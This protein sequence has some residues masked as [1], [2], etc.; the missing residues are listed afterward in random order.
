MVSFSVGTWLKLFYISGNKE[1]I[2]GINSLVDH[3]SKNLEHNQRSLYQLQM[4]NV[5]LSGCEASLCEPVTHLISQQN[6][7][8]YSLSLSGYQKKLC[9]AFTGL[10]RLQKLSLNG[11]DM[12]PARGVLLNCLSSINNLVYL[13]LADTK[14]T[15]DMTRAVV[16]LLSSWPGLVF[17][18][19]LTV[20]KVLDVLSQRLRQLTSLGYVNVSRGGLN[21][22]Q[23]VELFSSL[24]QSVEVIFAVGNDTQ[25]DIISITQTLASLPN[26]KYAILSLNDVSADI[27]FQLEAA[28]QLKEAVIINRSKD[29]ILSE[30][31]LKPL[32]SLA[33]I[34]YYL[35]FSVPMSTYY[36]LLYLY[37]HYQ[38]TYTFE[39][40]LTSY[41]L[42]ISA[43]M[44]LTFYLQPQ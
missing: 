2:E 42:A 19:G 12:T 23:L 7:H 25:D 3:I 20:G 14:L 26:L 34:I 15:E 37:L 17:L 41:P 27:T 5:T 30:G 10:P 11:T 43:K 1:N 33:I 35:K 13:D 31:L 16:G 40:I 22:L 9:E 18:S 6:L 38:C 8:L 21:T 44:A 39:E 29:L 28:F 4:E 36:L 32:Q 24:P